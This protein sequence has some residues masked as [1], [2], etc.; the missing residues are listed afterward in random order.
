MSP[1]PRWRS[2]KSPATEVTLISTA[3]H[4]RTEFPFTD[5]ACQVVLEDAVLILASDR[6]GCYGDPG[7][8]I[9]VLVSLVAEAQAWLVELVAD[10]RDFGYTWDSIADRLSCSASTA[11]HRYAAHAIWRRDH[12]LPTD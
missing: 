11:R 3:R 7:A 6:G 5:R 10:A 4:D 12:P 2:S 9:S 8:S 1:P